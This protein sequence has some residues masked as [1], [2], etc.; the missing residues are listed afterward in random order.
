[1]GAWWYFGSSNSSSPERPATVAQVTPDNPAPE[2]P[3]RVAVEP[4]PARDPKPVF[5]PPVKPPEPAAKPRR[6]APEVKAPPAQ[7]PAPV[8]QVP[9]PAPLAPLPPIDER[10][11]VPDAPIRAAAKEVFVDL[12]ERNQGGTL[13]GGVDPNTLP[14][15]TKAAEKGKE[16]TP[17]NKQFTVTMPANVPNIERSRVL[18]VR[19]R[20]M[21]L[22]M[23]QS[24][25]PDGTM[26][27]AG[28]IGIPATLA[29]Q[30]PAE[31]RLEI[32]RDM[33]AQEM[34]GKVT[35]EK[36]I[37]QGTRI[38][39]DYLIEGPGGAARVRTYLHG[40]WVLYALV[41]GK[42]KARVN[43]TDAEWFF[44]AFRLNG[45]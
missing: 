21:P 11:R 18:S 5:D 34:P 13:I 10:K 44:D 41:Q 1:V 8:V 7:V 22:E 9:Q 40:G 29:R 25:L 23:S 2:A 33:L 31:T 14:P 26:F 15:D 45:Q 16:Y 36:D 28:S 32:I 6:P 37:K 24:T 43:F 39:K 12:P 20:P 42:N 35:D 38:G 19:G 27:T 17:K 3:G 30:I 4:A